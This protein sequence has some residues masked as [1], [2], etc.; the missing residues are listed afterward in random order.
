MRDWKHPDVSPSMD[1][2]KVGWRGGEVSDEFM[3]DIDG[4]E[5][6]APASTS[7]C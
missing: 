4:C 6:L 7:A 1:Q 2:G 3:L 5:M